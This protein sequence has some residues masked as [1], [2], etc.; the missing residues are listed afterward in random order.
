MLYAIPN[1][2]MTSAINIGTMS[3]TQVIISGLYL[4]V[5]SVNMLSSN[6]DKRRPYK[7]EAKPQQH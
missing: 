7:P 4:S 2:M 5:I 6:S 1:T 3:F